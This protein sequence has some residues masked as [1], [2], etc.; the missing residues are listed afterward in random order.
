MLM[1]HINTSSRAGSILCYD[2][3]SVVTNVLFIF[4]HI[5]FSF[6]LCPECWVSPSGETG[7]RCPGRPGR[8]RGRWGE[9][10]SSGKT[11]NDNFPDKWFIYVG[12]CRK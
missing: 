8:G 12:I 4:L 10:G 3:L 11:C 2:V 7:L 1:L 5:L 9:A 6:H